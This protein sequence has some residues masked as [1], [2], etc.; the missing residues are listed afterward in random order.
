MQL[1]H[2]VAVLEPHEVWIIEVSLPVHLPRPLAK[3][4]RNT[5]ESGGPVTVNGNGA[6]SLYSH[7]EGLFSVCL[8]SDHQRRSCYRHR[9]R[10]SVTVTLKNYA[11]PCSWRGAA[12]RVSKT[13]SPQ[14]RTA[15]NP[16]HNARGA[17]NLRSE[18]WVP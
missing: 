2:E 4:G 12:P 6:N 13:A 5:L 15:A 3:V 16:Q 17:K 10:A 14:N 9:E 18:G 7:L 8:A 1:H 11:Q